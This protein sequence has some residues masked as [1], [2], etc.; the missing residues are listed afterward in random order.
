MK[1]Y[2]VTVNVIVQV[3]APSPTTAEKQ[4][5]QKMEE[6]FE[7]SDSYQVIDFDVIDVA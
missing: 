4:V 1:T 7:G 2:D 3:E 5:I 6:I